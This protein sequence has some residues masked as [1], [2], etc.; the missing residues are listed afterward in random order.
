[1]FDGIELIVPAG[2]ESFPPVSEPA[3][4]EVDAESDD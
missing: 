2:A 3:A 1:M 4:E